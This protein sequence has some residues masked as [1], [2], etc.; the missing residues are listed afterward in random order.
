MKA[1]MLMFDSLNRNFLPPYGCD[2]THAP[3]FARFAKRAITFDRA[4]VGSLPCMPAR[5]EL[6][7]GRYN[8]LH[9]SW[10]PL[11]PF[12]DSMPE[13]LKQSG[14]HTHLC[15][16][17]YHYFEDG[18]A[19]YHGRYSTW[20]FHR[21]Q[22]GD[23]WIGQVGEPPIPKNINQKR[24]SDNQ[25]W[26]NRQFMK[27]AGQHSQE[28]TVQGGLDF[29]ERN[30]NEDNWFLQIEAFDPHEPF[31]SRGFYEDLYPDDYD[32]PLFDWP[33]YK[34]V[35]ESPEII[36]HL[37][38]K[39]AALLS[40]CDAHLGKVLDA[41]DENGLWNDTMLIV[42]TDHGFLL[43]EHNWLGKGVMPLYEEISHTP[44]FMW[45]P[46]FGHAGERRRALVQPSIDLGP[47]LLE[48]FGQEPTPDMMGKPLRPV[49]ERDEPIRDAALFGYFGSRL[50]VTDGR[51]VYLREPVC[52][53]P[54]TLFEY[55]LMPTA[56]RS[57]S[58]FNDKLQDVTLSE[59]FSFTKGCRLLKM[60]IERPTGQEKAMRDP[61]HQ[62]RHLLFDLR[63]DPEQKHPL[64]DAE[65]EE[66]MKGLMKELMRQADAPPE[67]FKRMGLE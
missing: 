48:Y 14:V 9:R 16:D 45:D 64:D 21:G 66:R 55:T 30:K 67:R 18:G 15:T 44:F 4:Y 25:D 46:R 56:M 41:M 23:K 7:T 34:E 38:N 8:F 63:N 40:M 2:W 35:D 11:E 65:I 33:G 47:T 57:L 29:I 61:E 51:Y 20:E 49:I 28:R 32:G 10:G 52:R 42:W 5:R 37:R 54:G 31:F 17:H 12:D 6:H 3:N 19:T 58:H 36:N 60:E 26:I 13:L 27:A 39:Y 50:N 22:E 43:G 24:H 62:P 1:I 59:P 53:E